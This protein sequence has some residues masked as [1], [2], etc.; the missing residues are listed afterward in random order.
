MHYTKL[1]WF[2]DAHLL[3]KSHTVRYKDA[4]VRYKLYLPNATQ[5]LKMW[6]NF[7]QL[8]LYFWSFRLEIPQCEI[9]KCE[10][11]YHK[12]TS[13]IKNLV[14]FFYKTLFHHYVLDFTLE[15]AS[16]WFHSVTQSRTVADSRPPPEIKGLGSWVPL[17]LSLM[18]I[19][20]A[21]NVE[22]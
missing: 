5:Y 13:Y 12:S 2:L 19:K 10:F 3:I 1:H 21:D 14:T 15:M 17:M 20:E 22:K 8:H 7:L 18:I 4:F 6:C 11:I 9:S 16:I